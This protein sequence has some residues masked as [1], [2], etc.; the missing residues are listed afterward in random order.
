MATTFIQPFLKKFLTDNFKPLFSSN[1]LGALGNLGSNSEDLIKKFGSLQEFEITGNDLTQAFGN[2]VRA[3]DINKNNKLPFQSDYTLLNSKLR[4]P[5]NNFSMTAKVGA[6]QKSPTLVEDASILQNK[7]I[8]PTV[9]DR[10]SRDV[11][12]T[13]IGGKKFQNPV[14]TFGGIQFMDDGAQGWASMMET[15][16][17]YNRTLET[18]EQMGGQPVGMT[19]TMGGLGSDF[20]LDTANVLIESLRVSEIPK[21]NLNKITEILENYTKT[22]KPIGKEPYQIQ[23]FSK[24]PNLN[25]I[26]EF[27]NYFRSLPGSMRSELVKRFDKAELQNLGTP[28]IGQVR[29]SITNPGLIAEDFLGMGTRFTDLKSGVV[30]SSHPSYDSQVMK[31]PGAETYTFGTSV[32]KTIMLREPMAK[33][34]AEG[35]GFGTFKSMPADLRK[36]TFNTPVQVADQQ[37]I[38]EA[39]KYLEIKRNIGDREAY[40]YAQKLIPAT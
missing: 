14:R 4:D 8:I 1:Q 22:V 32:P 13:G 37:L 19:T 18:V 28:N 36:L 16:K 31:A 25:D 40:E 26:E 12:I 21:E 34:R 23:P 38:D 10:S 2:K 33:V 29:L 35:K 17:A 15:M 6:V 7:T 30:K 39:S 11:I 20:S 9:G 3:L 24:V 27:A 5:L